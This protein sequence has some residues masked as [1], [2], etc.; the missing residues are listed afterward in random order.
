MNKSIITIGILACLLPA[1]ALAAEFKSGESL[2]IAASD[3]IEDDLYIAGGTVRIEGNVNGDLIIA[4]GNV[5]VKG[6]VS[7]DITAAGGNVVLSGTIGDDLRAAGGDIR[8]TGPVTDDVLI[9]G[10]IVTIA[11]T[12]TVGGQLKTGAGELTVAGK[13]TTIEAAGEKVTLAKTAVVAG[14]LTYWS[15]QQAT[16]EQGAAVTGKTTHNTVKD[17]PVRSGDNLWSK[18]F[19]TLTA[20]LFAYIFFLLFP[21]KTAAV[22]DSINMKAFTN[23]WLGLAF[24][25]LV[26]IVAIITIITIVGIPVSIGILLLYPIF[27]YLGSLVTT[28]WLGDRAMR[29][30]NKSTEK[31]ITAPSIFV[32][33]VLMTLLML[34]PY[35]GPIM[36]FLLFMTGLGS[37]VRFDWEFLSQLRADKKI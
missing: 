6:N 16:I 24:T 7:G 26:P 11:E 5:E 30:L 10:G 9:A 2:T 14:D 31:D 33:A 28:V 20:A 8:V 15:S 37:L 35:V 4:G 3:T 22:I 36:S 12:A 1:T 27:M 29:L 25:I 17:E 18:L 21:V 32:G 13:V 34:I 19:S 23:F